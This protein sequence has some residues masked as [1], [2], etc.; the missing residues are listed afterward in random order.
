M[1]IWLKKYAHMNLMNIVNTIHAIFKMK[2]TIKEQQIH[3]YSRF[4]V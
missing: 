4:I 3:I 1:L 2:S